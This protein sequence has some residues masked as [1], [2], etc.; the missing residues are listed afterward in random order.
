VPAAEAA[1]L[2]LINFVVPRNQLEA[3]TQALV[4]ELANGP[5]RAHGLNK[6]LINNS[7]NSD[8]DTQAG[9][10]MDTYHVGAGTDD[11]LEGTAAFVQK[12]PP[13]FKG[14]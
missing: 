10:E 6:A 12:R 11:W 2:G 9:R 13:V 3:E 8:F 7:L 1:R 4:Q 5:T 14:R